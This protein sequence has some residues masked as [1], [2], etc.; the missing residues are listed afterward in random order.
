M[1]VGGLSRRIDTFY[2]LT[3]NTRCSARRITGYILN[4]L[5]EVIFI[6][7]YRHHKCIIVLFLLILYFALYDFTIMLLTVRLYACWDVI[8]VKINSLF[9]SILL[10]SL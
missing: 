8:E 6:V 2:L 9:V 1:E 3:L 5:R 4:I 7:F 10:W